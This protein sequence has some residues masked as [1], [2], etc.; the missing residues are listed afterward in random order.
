MSQQPQAH[1]P[2]SRA[3][4]ALML[5][6]LAFAAGCTFLALTFFSGSTASY[7]AWPMSGPTATLLGAAY[8]GSAAMLALALRAGE[9]V[10]VRVATATSALFMLLM[11]GALLAGHGTLQLTGGTLVAVLTAW[12]WLGVHTVAPLIGLAALAA[13][14]RTPGA[15]P[16]RPPRLP[17]WVAAPMIGN[18]TVVTAAGAVLYAFPDATAR[19]WP[20]TV[21]ALDVRVL[22]AWCLTFGIALL[23]SVREAELRRV[24]SGMAALV[25]TGSFGL[26]GLLRYGDRISW[27]SPGAWAVLLV[28]LSFTGLGLSGYAAS[29]L[30]DPPE[31]LVVRPTRTA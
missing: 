23:L 27:S 8:G 15:E 31:P 17:G 3:L 10:K 30:L 12:G 13:Q 28:L 16:P 20:W 11:L 24:R 1:R 7:F 18:G 6:P 19:H 5:A 4:K 26:L 9:W 22:G 21:T 25:C 14:W 29:A 2:V